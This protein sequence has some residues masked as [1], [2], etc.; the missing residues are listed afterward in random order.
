MAYTE[1]PSCLKNNTSTH[2]TP[3]V[4]D[5]YENHSACP[6]KIICIYLENL[7]EENIHP[8]ETLIL[9]SKN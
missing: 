9:N 7:L 1:N 3:T 5:K 6:N 2:K 4:I 8:E